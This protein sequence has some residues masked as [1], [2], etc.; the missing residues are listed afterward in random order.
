MAT[1]SIWAGVTQLY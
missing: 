1:C